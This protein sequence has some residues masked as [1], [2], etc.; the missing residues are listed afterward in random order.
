MF[1][2]GPRGSSTSRPPEVDCLTSEVDVFDLRGRVVD[3][4]GQCFESWWKHVLRDR[5]VDLRGRNI[6]LRGRDVDLGRST[7]RAPP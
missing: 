6:H 5:K 7:F 3:T 4:G 2:P 1:R